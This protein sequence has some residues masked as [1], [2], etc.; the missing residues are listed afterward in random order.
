M[1]ASEEFP[2]A[3][4]STF[5]GRF[6]IEEML[7]SGGMGVVVAARHLA[8]KRRVAIKVLRPE[9]AESGDAGA[10]APATNNWVVRFVREARAVARL[11]S[12][13]VVDVLDVGTLPTGV[14]YYVMEYL[15][16]I[17]LETLVQVRGPLA[18]G[19]V[20]DYTL[21]ALEA[22]AEAHRHGIIHRDLKPANLFLT[23]REDDT[24]FIKVL[25]FGVSKLVN[26]ET[27]SDG[28]VTRQ[29]AMLGSPLYMAPEQIQDASTVD[30]RSDIWSFGAVMHEL[31]VGKPPFDAGPIAAVIRA[32]CT[33]TY[34]PP[35]GADLPPEL[36]KIIAR[37]LRKSREER[38]QS[39]EEL[40]LAFRPLA[41]TSAAHVSINRIL[42]IRGSAP[43]PRLPI[44]APRAE[45][46]DTL[47]GTRFDAPLPSVTPVE[48]DTVHAPPAGAMLRLFT[49]AFGATGALL[50]ALW[51]AY[52]LRNTPAPAPS[53]TSPRLTSAPAAAAR[54]ER[55]T[56]NVPPPVALPQPLV[57]QP[58]SSAAP[59]AQKTARTSGERPSARLEASILPA[60]APAPPAEPAM[61]VPHRKLRT[62]DTD[63]PFRK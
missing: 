40:A 16:G 8:L 10:G 62:L 45:V 17:D 39:V 57:V 49:L 14:P 6:L 38:F 15:S 19:D 13:H 36:V 59:K 58:A 51:L 26:W 23:T 43:P 29:G 55:S 20:V 12:E 5:D 61:P 33:Q 35:E 22:L 28:T 44:A 11:K 54:S 47:A 50:T 34:R 27:T 4:G 48:S 41:R 42:R 9:L 2:P 52:G 46:D 37:C 56:S 25:D 32:I 3:T 60:L 31:L 18:L 1:P 30:E 7:G 53:V 21:Q 63:N 24:G